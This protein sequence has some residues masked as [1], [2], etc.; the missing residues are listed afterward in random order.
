MCHNM[1]IMLNYIGEGVI[2]M[3]LSLFVKVFYLTIYCA[4][5]MLDRFSGISFSHIEYLPLQWQSYYTM[6]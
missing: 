1:S 4:N 3:T 2:R 5:Y 6:H